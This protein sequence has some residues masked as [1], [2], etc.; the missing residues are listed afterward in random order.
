MTRISY[1]THYGAQVSVDK[2]CSVARCKDGRTQMAFNF[3]FRRF[4]RPCPQGCENMNS[5]LQQ[6]ANIIPMFFTPSESQ[7][8]SLLSAFSSHA[9]KK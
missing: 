3:A 9:Q 8:Y 6:F 5:T 2:T 1:S 4:C 7:H